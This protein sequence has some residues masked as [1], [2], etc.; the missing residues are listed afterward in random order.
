MF[1]RA[2]VRTPGEN[3]CDGITTSRLGRPDRRKTLE[4]HTAYCDA[5]RDCGVEVSVLTADERFPD[6]CFVEDTAVVT[7]DCAVI[8]R[9]GAPERR[10][11]EEAIADALA[12]F[13]PLRRIEEPATLD[14]GDVMRVSDQFY[15]GLSKR[16]NAEGALQLTSALSEHGHVVSTI[17]VNGVLHLKTGVT[18]VGDNT[19]VATGEFAG[20]DEFNAFCRIDVDETAAA[21]CLNVN[22]TILVPAGFPKTA[23]ALRRLRRPVIELDISEFRKMDGGLTCLSLLF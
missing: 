4:Q 19:L 9:L 15:V 17:P 13:R 14:G 16:T 21:N 1:T 22:G 7:E 18:F 11:E 5:L 10:G 8:A 20:R 2:I 3:F 6:G 23:S 12:A